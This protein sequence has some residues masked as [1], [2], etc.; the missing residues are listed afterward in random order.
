VAKCVAKYVAKARTKKAKVA[1]MN[2]GTR[3]C[4][5]SERVGARE[6]TADV[7]DAEDASGASVEHC[8][9]SVGEG[10]SDGSKSQ[11]LVA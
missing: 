11:T 7:G 4:I 10:Y 2:D 6:L 5:P 3:I 1:S 9:P 8:C